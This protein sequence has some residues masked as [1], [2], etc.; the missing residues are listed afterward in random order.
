MRSLVN[1][2]AAAAA[3]SADDHARCKFT[4]QSVRA[5]PI[6]VVTVGKGRSPGLR[7]LLDDYS[8]KLRQFCAV[9]LVHLRSNPKNA[10]DKRV[11]VRDEDISVSCLLRPDDWVAML[12]ERGMDIGS[13]RLAELIAGAG[14][15]GASKLTFCLGGPYGHGP[16]LRERADVSIK[17][18]SMVLNHEVALV[19]LMEQ[20]YRS[21]TI[22][23]GLKY[24]H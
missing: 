23:K 18:S 19:V 16:K 2:A 21:W 12:D 17:L 5:V 7:L 13:E 1:G 10:R 6:R 15:T 20:L 11:Q 22:L 9:E 24:H 8:D 14:N 3:S 4:G